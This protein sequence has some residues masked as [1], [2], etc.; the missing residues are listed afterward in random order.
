MTICLSLKVPCDD[1]NPRKLP[2][3]YAPGI[4][5]AADAR[6]T[7]DKNSK[8]VDN[9]IKIWTLSDFAVACFAG[10]VQIAEISLVSMRYSIDE[11]SLTKHESIAHAIQNWLNYY[12][13][14]SKDREISLTEVVVSIYD[15]NSKRFYLYLLSSDK[16]FRPE[17]RDGI[18]TIGSGSD[19]YRKYLLKEIDHHNVNISKSDSGLKVIQTNKG[20]S[21]VP[22]TN[23]DRI[24]KDLM[25]IATM[26]SGSMD[27]FIKKSGLTSVGGLVQI[28]MLNN[29]GVIP[30]VGKIRNKS[31]KKWESITA[32]N[33]QSYAEMMKRKFKIPTM[34]KDLSIED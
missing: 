28:Y 33:L 21:V 32:S 25:T 6:F 24:E 34:R 29:T 13:N 8:S 20:L 5:I 31:T 18:I 12:K 2:L 23:D 19:K 16:F 30:L 10:D 22:R 26:I 7:W 27:L 15:K 9:G 17:R 1:L 3:K 14:L 4:V 11:L